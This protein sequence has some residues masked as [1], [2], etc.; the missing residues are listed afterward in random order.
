MKHGIKNTRGVSGR[1]ELLIRRGRSK[2]VST[3]IDVAL[4][5]KGMCTAIQSYFDGD[6]SSYR[7]GG[8]GGGITILQPE[9]EI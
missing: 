2:A 8:R 3:L 1:H 7:D 5:K 4:Q 9:T 6:S